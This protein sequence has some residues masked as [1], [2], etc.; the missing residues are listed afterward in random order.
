MSFATAN[1]QQAR[2]LVA[3]FKATLA[4]LGREWLARQWAGVPSPGFLSGYAFGGEL[5]RLVE[6]CTL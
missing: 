5:D 4:M 3:V 2:L 1:A 6:L